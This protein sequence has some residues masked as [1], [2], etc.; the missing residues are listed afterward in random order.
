MDIDP[1]PSSTKGKGRESIQI[2]QDVSPW[3]EKYRPTELHVCRGNPG[4]IPPVT[5]FV[6]VDRVPHMLFYGP[7]GTG[8]TSTI[9][10]IARKIYGDKYRGMILELNASDDRG[11]DVVRDQIRT[12]ASTRQIFSSAFKLIVLDEA[13]AMTTAAQNALRRIVEKYTANVRFCIICNYVN[14]IIPAIQSRCTRFRFQP[15]PITE[16]TE[17]GK[18]ALLR[19]SK[20]DM[21]RALNV[22]QACHAAYDYIDGVDVY[23]CVGNPQPQDIT[24]I[25]QSM[26]NEEFTVSLNTISTI[27][28]EKGLALQDILG[29]VYEVLQE[30]QLRG[31]VRIYILDQLATIEHR[32][33]TGSCEKI[34][35]SAMIAAIQLG[36]QLANLN[37]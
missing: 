33:S 1:L 22:L 32:L 26:M 17:A 25:V 4:L 20:G 37:S 3:V 14:K 34:Q 24:K 10:A 15:L 19:L 6:A 11:I 30:T 7:P 23:N 27:K 28:T 31:N 16:I 5:K 9:L 36:L 13:D 2:T 12:F 8:K 35:L 21:R 29:G 18:E